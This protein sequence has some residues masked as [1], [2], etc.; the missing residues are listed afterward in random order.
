MSLVEM[1]ERPEAEISGRTYIQRTDVQVLNASKEG[2]E[3]RFADRRKKQI[4]MS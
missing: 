3:C 1:K 4:R 2:S